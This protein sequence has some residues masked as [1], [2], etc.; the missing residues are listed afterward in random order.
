MQTNIIPLLIIYY[1][2]LMII[3]IITIKFNRSIDK[4][5]GFL[6]IIFFLLI[7]TFRPDNF[8]DSKPY[9]MLFDSIDKYDMIWKIGKNPLG[10]ENWFINLTKIIDY[11]INSYRFYFFIIGSLNLYIYIYSLLSLISLS[12]DTELKKIRIIPLLLIFLPYFGIMYTAIALRAGL[13]ISFG[14][15]SLT[16]IIRKKFLFA[17][18]FSFLCIAF[19]D[20]GIIMVLA[21]LLFNFIP[22][23][24]EKVYLNASIFL[25]LLYITKITN[26]F[27]NDLLILLNIIFDKVPVFNLIR[28]YINNYLDISSIENSPIKL[29]I[30]FFL[31]Q[32]FFL[33]TIAK[34]RHFTY[35][36]KK[37]FNIVF[38]GSI[39]AVFFSFLPVVLRGLDMYFVCIIPVISSLIYRR[40]YILIDM[41]IKNTSMVIVDNALI[42]IGFIGICVIYLLMLIRMVI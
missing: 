25:L 9:M 37:I 29:S 17:I 34:K 16:F 5:I 8:P 38:I 26:L 27:N 13:A 7:I 19:H 30:L 42:M 22:S 3:S 15:L 33:A 12:L 31:L 39:I 18:I 32:F 21:I 40:N 36:Q 2:V 6:F 41:E 1:I 24:S 20:S 28:N 23:F 10:Y 35:I 14:L 11:F 4:I